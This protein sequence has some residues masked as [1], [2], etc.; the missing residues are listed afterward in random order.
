MPLVRITFGDLAT[1][2][3]NVAVGEYGTGNTDQQWLHG[4]LGAYFSGRTNGDVTV[5]NG[6]EYEIEASGTV[7][8]QGGFSVEKGATFAVYPSCF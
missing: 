8:L 7:T 2:G 6:V 3:C 1:T 5:K 4:R